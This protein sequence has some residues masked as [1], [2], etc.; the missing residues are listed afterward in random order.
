MRTGGQV[1]VN[2]PSEPK[3]VGSEIRCHRSIVRLLSSAGDGSRSHKLACSKTG[4]SVHDS[5]CLHYKSKMRCHCAN[6][7]STIDINLIRPQKMPARS[8]SRSTPQCSRC[9]EFRSQALL[10]PWL[11]AVPFKLAFLMTCYCASDVFWYYIFLDISFLRSCRSC[12]CL[13]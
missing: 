2:P 8:R 4:S 5:D 9:P 7:E 12:L 6:T 13:D 10:T 11:L 3:I 1:V